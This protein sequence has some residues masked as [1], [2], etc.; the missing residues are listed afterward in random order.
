[1]EEIKTVDLFAKPQRDASGKFVKGNTMTP[2]DKVGN[3]CHYCTNKEAVLKKIQLFSL[4]TQG[5]LPDKKLHMPYI[6]DLV[7]EDFL[8]VVYDT[9]L[10]WVDEKNDHSRENHA[11]LIQTYKKLFTRQRGMLLKRTLSQN[12]TGAI[13][14]LKVNHGYVETEKRILAGDSQ[15]PV[16]EKLEIEITEAKRNYE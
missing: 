12:A 13:F 10:N 14:Q 7:D 4:W 3:V 1:M 6:E 15:N 2:I 5:K 8:D 11:E 16:R 9:F